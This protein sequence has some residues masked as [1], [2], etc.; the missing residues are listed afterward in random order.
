MNNAMAITKRNDGNE[1]TNDL[2]SVARRLADDPFWK[3]P[4]R[5]SEFKAPSLDLSESEDAYLIELEAPGLD[6]DDLEVTLSDNTL[7][8]KGKK[9]REEEHEDRDYH[10]TERRFGSF[11]RQVH[12]PDVASEDEVEAE[13]ERGILSVHIPKA[14]EART[15]QID[16]K[17]KEK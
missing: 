6:P 9:V 14:T 15:K 7:T 1:E 4:S 10:R 3:K 8:L 13:Y 2:F 17:V 12:L 11:T 16:V 5:W